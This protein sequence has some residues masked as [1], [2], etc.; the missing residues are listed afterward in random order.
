MTE[1]EKVAEAETPTIE[2][3]PTSEVDEPDIPESKSAMVVRGKRRSGGEVEPT[4]AKIELEW[5]EDWEPR[6]PVCG[7]PIIGKFA[8]KCPIC[9]ED[10]IM[11]QYCYDAHWIKEHRDQAI[12]VRIEIEQHMDKQGKFSDPTGKWAISHGQNA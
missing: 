7:K 12:V 5:N 3:P 9:T 1:E 4:E 8:V 11:H 2:T 10:T 6:C